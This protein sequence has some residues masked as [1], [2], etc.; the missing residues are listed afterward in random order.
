MSKRILLCDG[1]Y[2]VDASDGEWE[3]DR[4]GVPR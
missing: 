3:D 4:A 2:V 1:C